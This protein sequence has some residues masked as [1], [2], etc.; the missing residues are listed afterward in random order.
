MADQQDDRETVTDLIARAQSAMLT[1]LTP[2]GELV[3]RPMAVQETEFDG[4]LWFFVSEDSD[5]VRQ[6]MAHPRVNVSLSNDKKSEW[7]SISGTAEVV[8]DRAKTKDLWAKPL[9]TWF[10]DGPETPGLALIKV[11]AESAEYWNA[12][13]SKVKATAGKVVM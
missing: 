7:I 11:R 1:T 3:S 13:T 9:E 8:H 10:P 2:D 6:I 12:A 4:D 5:K